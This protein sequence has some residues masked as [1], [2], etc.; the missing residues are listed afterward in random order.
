MSF[1]VGTFQREDSELFKNNNPLSCVKIVTELKK[2]YLISAREDS[3]YQVI[4]L[5]TKEYYNPKNNNWV[6]INNN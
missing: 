6:K 3:D 2:E 4:R 1:L 5:S